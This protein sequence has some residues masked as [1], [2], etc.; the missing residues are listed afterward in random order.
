MR[1][2]EMTVIF[3]SNEEE[4]AKGKQQVDEL[5]QKFGITV[6]SS[7]DLN[8]RIL[9][10]PVKKEEKG[11]YFTYQFQSE[12][13]T[14]AQLDRALKLLQPVLKFLVVRKD[15]EETQKAPKQKSREQQKGSEQPE[16]NA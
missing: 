13:N 10:Y 3:R 4:F 12:P 15:E 2:Y 11:H 16:A 7:E 8:V 6:D 9:A 1:P 14:I 5:L